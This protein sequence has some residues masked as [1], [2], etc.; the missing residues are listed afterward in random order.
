MKGGQQAKWANSAVQIVLLFLGLVSTLAL[1]FGQSGFPEPSFLLFMSAVFAALFSAVF[2]LFKGRTRAFLLLGIFGAWLL[3]G[4]FARGYFSH[5]MEVAS[6]YIAPYL[7]Q[8]ANLELGAAAPTQEGAQA[9]AAFCLYCVF[10]YAGFLAWA[11]VLRRSAL[12]SLLATIPLFAFSYGSLTQPAG[13]PLA[14]LFVFWVS[15][16]LQSRVL[17]TAK[18]VK[19]GFSLLCAALAAGV[20]CTLFAAFPQETYTASK[21]AVN[22]RLDITNTA[23]DFG[24]SIRG[25][26]GFPAGTPL[27][28]SDGTVSLDTT[29]SV[30]FADREVMRVHCDQPESL[31]LRGYSAS[32]YTGHEWLQPDEQAFAESNAGIKPLQY[33]GTENLLPADSVTTTVTVE[34][35]RTDSNFLF[36]PYLLVDITSADPAPSWY[37]D[38][39]LAADGQ[40]S[41]TFETYNTYGN[42][43]ISAGSV[44]NLWHLSMNLPQYRGSMEFEG[45]TFQY[46][47]FSIGGIL[48]PEKSGVPSAVMEGAQAFLT[49][50]FFMGGTDP[51]GLL[52]PQESPDAGYRAYIQSEYTQLPVGLR[53][54]LLAWWSDRRSGENLS[55]EMQPFYEP[56]GDIPPPLLGNGREARR[57][58]GF[59]KRRLYRKSRPTAYKPRF[60]GIF[61]HRGKAGILHPL[62]ERHHRYAAR[63]RNPR[64]LCGRVCGRKRFVRGRRLGVRIRE[65]G[66]L[67]GRN[68]DAGNRLGSGRID[69][70]RDGRRRGCGCVRSTRSRGLALHGS[71]PVSSR[72]ARNARSLRL[73][74]GRCANQSAG[75]C[76]IW[77]GR[78]R[79]PSYRRRI[80][81]LR[82]VYL[83]PDGKKKARPADGRPRP[84]PRRTWNLRIPRRS[85]RVRRGNFAGSGSNRTQSKI[86][87]ACHSPGRARATARRTPGGTRQ[88]REPPNV[89][90]KVP[91]LAERPVNLTKNTLDLEW[92][93]GVTMSLSEADDYDDCRSK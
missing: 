18:E 75:S 1:F 13:V 61:S 89:R 86:Q 55:P 3:A 27:S 45:Y 8:V 58:G 20:F 70:G 51:D 77:Q 31:Y 90:Q 30:Q 76:G 57:V 81:C 17:R 23:L 25:L 21:D 79:C 19:P 49:D 68:L 37:G 60:C 93:P 33:L 54:T 52:Q 72:A 2:L 38:A 84:Q 41:Y 87:P 15:M 5:G 16:I 10:P 26:R 91:V 35:G 73:L 42:A 65:P 88:S 6:G 4:V 80:P 32:V 48:Y 46:E 24:Y 56:S 12:F 34:P 22:L 66:A 7:A 64:P 47:V 43:F 11:V 85:P 62:R 44:S 40:A 28:S 63:S 92:A 82:P 71:N 50:V 83:P 74:P 59:Q 78:V 53:E 14:L 9:C 29:G 36:T 67:L 69:T 39:Y